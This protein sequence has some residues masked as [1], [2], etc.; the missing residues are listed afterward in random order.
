M[1]KLSSTRSARAIAMGAVCLVLSVLAGPGCGSDEAGAAPP[2]AATPGGATIGAAGGVVVSADGRLTLTIPPGALSA[3]V[4]IRVTAVTNEEVPE[5]LR[6]P[7]S[8]PDYRLEPDGTTFAQPVKVEVRTTG[9]TADGGEGLVR[10]PGRVLFST[11]PEHG[12][13]ALRTPDRPTEFGSTVLLA[14]KTVVAVGL[15][16][17]FSFVHER[18]GGI[19][20]VVAQQPKLP[21]E[22]PYRIQIAIEDGTPE[23]KVNRH[24]LVSATAKSPVT[25]SFEEKGADL[26]AGGRYS[27]G[28]PFECEDSGKGSYRVWI[29]ADK[30]DVP[31]TIP[32][33]ISNGKEGTVFGFSGEELLYWVDANGERKFANSIE[34][35]TEC[36][37]SETLNVACCL[38]DESCVETNYGDC[39]ERNGFDIDAAYCGE[40]CK[41][42][43]AC[44]DADTSC[45]LTK[46]SECLGEFYADVKSCGGS[47]T[48]P[49]LCDGD[50]PATGDL[51]GIV[52]DMRAADSDTSY[53]G[54][55]ACGLLGI[56]THSNGVLEAE[57]NAHT[58]IQSKLK[59]EAECGQLYTDE[60]FNHSIYPCGQGASGFTICPPNP[61]PVPGGAFHIV[62]AA[63]G[64][65]LPL[66][67]PANRYQYAFVFDED[68]NPANNY[69][70]QPAYPSDF[71]K[72]TDRWYEANYVPGTGWSLKASNAKNG[73]VTSFPTAARIIVSGN[74]I[75][76]VVPKA[77]FAAPT[78]PYR[79]TAFR[80]KGDFGI[81]QPHDWD[82]DV[83][84][85][86]AS[87]LTP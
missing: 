14:D 7:T 63:L 67:D 9:L 70:P 55:V 66:A 8:G 78:P 13:E 47:F 27:E 64:G 21:L 45:T 10:V 39:R 58:C 72:G 68:G 49:F 85:P 20:F 53:L 12:I 30:I 29:L 48:C 28:I 60:L 80:H 23:L 4:A 59:T 87:G 75:V 2:A 40:L 42:P 34:V 36:V 5:A 51:V 24:V 25:T 73:S 32:I 38:P 83:E 71:F 76:L 16:D 41:R 19:S 6:V 82:G 31:P 43:S 54:A 52:N 17:H 69:Q 37:G 11:S 1:L 33:A 79:I 86:V 57:C 77:E 62:G 46:E 65:A 3:D 50:P 26:P 81:P 61:T 56:T 74:A 22:Y 44:C 15:L 18:D 35:E 84:P